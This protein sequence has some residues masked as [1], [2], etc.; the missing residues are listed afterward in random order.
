[1]LEVMR[2]NAGGWV[3]K[4]LF[5]V[6]IIV[7]VFA[8]GMSGMDTGND[9]VLATVNDQVIT[10]AEFEE[11]FQRM[12]ENVRNSN[13]DLS[14]AQLQTQQFKQVVLGELVNN[15]LLQAEAARLGV[16]ASD[17]EIFAGI[18][19]QPFFKNQAGVFD[20]NVYQ[21]AVRQLRMTPSQF[22]KNFK[23][24]LI[25]AKV[26][27]LVR[28]SG[29]V[30]SDQ[31]RQLFN[32][33]G[34][35]AR[36]DYIQVAPRDYVD[37]TTVDEEEVTAFYEENKDRFMIP[38]QIRLRYLAFTPAELATYQRSEER[39]A[40]KECASMSRSRR[41]PCLEKKKKSKTVVNT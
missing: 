21:M 8:F 30:T 4:I 29:T 31:V 36:I 9:P 7:F 2:E 39:R 38:A 33:V 19:S 40:G 26:K 1:M 13:P 18:S 25:A 16:S 3:V 37:S 34:E 5:A 20:P 22:E 35:Q 17:E 23:Q 15:K 6:I 24:D 32:W 11:T 12:A 27:N 10:R 28:Q 41:S 14:P